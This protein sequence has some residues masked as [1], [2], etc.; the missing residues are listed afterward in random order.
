MQYLTELFGLESHSKLGEIQSKVKVLLG[1]VLKNPTAYPERYLEDLQKA[2]N[3]PDSTVEAILS[4]QIWANSATKEFIRGIKTQAPSG[5]LH[6]LEGFMLGSND[7]SA[8]LSEE[9]D[10]IFLRK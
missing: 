9:L 3:L 8:T 6:T 4:S 5:E 7:V 2:C 1:M 10:M